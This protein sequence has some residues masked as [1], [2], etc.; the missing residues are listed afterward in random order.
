[1]S[2]Q[3]A[4]GLPRQR[5]RRWRHLVQRAGEM[6]ARPA[7]AHF[8]LRTGTSFRD[9]ASHCSHAQLSAQLAPPRKFLGRYRA[10]AV[11]GGENSP[12]QADMLVL[13]LDDQS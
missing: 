4:S 10:D 6:I 11:D 13:L 7:L 12:A 3:V 9:R 5:R 8:R 2:G 1:M